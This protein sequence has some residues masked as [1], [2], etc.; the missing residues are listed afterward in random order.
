MAMQYDVKS[1]YTASDAAVV[2]YR[3]RLKGLYV[4]VGTAGTLPVTVYDNASAGSGTALFKLGT[5]AAGAH[6][7]VIPGDGIL[8]VNGLFVDTGD[9]DSVTVIYG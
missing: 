1:A 7:V 2:T 4:V 6:T 8:A 9:A 5:T 3:T